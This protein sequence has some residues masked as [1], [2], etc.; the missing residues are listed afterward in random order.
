MMHPVS[1]LAYIDPASGSILLQAII[2]AAM[3]LC[4]RFRRSLAQVFRRSAVSKEPNR[5]ESK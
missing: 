2:A 5:E 3:G 1:I 4:F